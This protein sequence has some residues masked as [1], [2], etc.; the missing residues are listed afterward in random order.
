MRKIK[1]WYKRTLCSIFGHKEVWW[2][3]FRPRVERHNSSW[4][5]CKVKA[6]RGIYKKCARC[7]KKLS[8][9]E[10]L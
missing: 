3:E 8:D 7:G 5:N 10:R 2:Q 6:V 1:Q 4:K 9:F